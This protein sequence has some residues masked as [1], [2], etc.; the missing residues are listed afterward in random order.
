[1]LPAPHIHLDV[2]AI[3]GG[4]G[5]LYWYLTGVARLRMRPVP[6][7]PSGR[8]RASFYLGLALLMIVS[9]WPMHDVAEVSLYWVHMVNHLVITLVAPPLM[10]LGL[11]RP[12]AD[13]LFGHRLVL[14]WLR[15]LARPVAAF[16]IF[17]LGMIASHWPEVVA[18]SLRDELAHFS[19]HVFLFVT[20]W[21]VWIPVVSRSSLVGRLKPPMRM[22]YLFLNSILPTIPASFLTFSH[23]PIYPAYG[24]AALTFG[25]SAVEDQTIAGLIMKLGGTMLLWG[26]LAVTWFRWAKDEERW[27]QIEQD[28]RSS[29]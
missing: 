28:L 8:Q 21:L 23:V 24:D 18:L 27:D 15:P 4:V 17:N 20:G 12:L 25:L 2:W 3:L 10:I 14:P 7:S 1:M 13:H 22:V 26:V 5:L 29:A 19:I 9:N 16:A 6:P 11:N